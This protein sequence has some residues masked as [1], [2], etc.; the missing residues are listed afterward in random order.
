MA[1][2]YDL[3]V[4]GG[5]TG[6]YAAALRAAQLDQS[7]ALIERDLVGGTCL[8]RGCIP[9]KALLHSAEVYDTAREA[10]RFGVAV[11]GLSYDWGGVSKHKEQVV[12]KMHRGLE[13]LIEH[14][15]I[16]VIRETAALRGA[17]RI[18]AGDR[19]IEARATVIATGSVPKM[20]PGLEAGERVLTSDT[21]LTL[22]RVPSSAIVIG[23]GSV[24]VEFASLWA[25]FGS[26]VTIVEM[27]PSLVPLED[28]DIGKE[29]ARAFSKRGI[30]AMVGAKL[31]DTSVGDEAVKATVSTDGKTE[32]LE[33]EVLLVA[34]GRA[35]VSGEVGLDA[36]GVSPDERGFVPVDGHCR[37][38]AEGV[39]AVGDVL[40][41]PQLAHVAFA[42]GIL[43]AEQAGGK[44]PMPVNYHA[45]PRCTYCVPEVAAVGLTTPE[46]RERGADVVTKNVAFSGIGKAAILGD[47]TGFCK[48]VA[49]RG[50]EILG[51]HFIGPR[52]TELVAEAMLAV[53]WEAVPEEVAALIH[54]HP[55]LTESMG[56]AALALSGKALHTA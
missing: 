22:D 8:H 54:P 41:T 49:D 13:G 20:L 48:I 42:E 2:A 15:S 35:P 37:T 11:E 56:E 44:R 10:K 33:A 28:P 39:W 7:V 17:G 46:A 30:T 53:G 5:G 18:A 3:V 45:I 14:R 55:T 47:T 29:L 4:I 6:G 51:V 27:L 52:V 40:A 23:G 16:E 31:E 25:S 50:G 26:T 43:V 24:G 12:Q 21:A 38:S 32:E 34:V 19:E 1:D 36:I 9:T